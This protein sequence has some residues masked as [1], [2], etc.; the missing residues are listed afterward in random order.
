MKALFCLLLSTVLLSNPIRLQGREWHYLA[1]PPRTLSG[2]LVRASAQGSVWIR[3]AAGAETELP[4]TALSKADRIYVEAR[5]AAAS[6]E[7]AAQAQAS[8]SPVGKAR[9]KKKTTVGKTVT[10]AARI[11]E[12]AN[13][14]AP[15][16]AVAAAPSSL[17]APGPTEISPDDRFFK[18]IYSGWYS[19][20][21]VIGLTGTAVYW[22]IDFAG[23]RRHILAPMERFGEGPGWLFYRS[24][25]PMGHVDWA[26]AD[27]EPW[28]CDGVPVYFR[29]PGHPNWTLYDRDY[30]EI[31]Y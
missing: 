23:H 14:I 2:S 15:P 19:T 9:T 20:F 4:L 7:R 3:D 22:R 16:T 12:L 28:W 11:S 8:S 18:R 6:L 26:L 17:P 31:P 27:R 13:N 1:D 10:V 21:H 30:R 25:D 29:T 5:R 24:H